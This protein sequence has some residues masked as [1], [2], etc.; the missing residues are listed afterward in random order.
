[1]SEKRP[2][3]RLQIKYTLQPSERER[4]KE[5]KSTLI[6]GQ[7]LDGLEICYASKLH[8]LSPATT[9]MLRK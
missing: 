6:R 7:L 4:R 9:S 5:R 1:M 8:I 3:V 2:A